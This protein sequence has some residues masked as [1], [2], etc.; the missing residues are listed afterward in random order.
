MRIALCLEYPIALRGGVSVLVEAM[1]K[2]FIRRGNEIVLV[3]DDDT[4]VLLKTDVG[5]LLTGH[6]RW[7]PQK[8]SRQSSKK[9]AQQ[10]A[11]AQVDLT[12]FHF[13]GHYGWGNRFPFNSPIY[14]LDRINIPCISTTHSLAGIFEGYCG[15][16]KPAWF[17]VCMFPLA[18]VGKMQQ[19]RCVHREIAVSQHNLKKL[20]KWYLPLKNRF[21][22]IYH[23][24][25]H[26]ELIEIPSINR[27]PVI[28]N[29]G[30][31]AKHK[32]QVLLAEAFGKIAGRFPGWTL[33][34]AG[35]DL[36]GS[37][38]EKIRRIA[39]EKLLDGR[40]QLL[41][42]RADAAEMMR[43]SAIYVQ[44][45][46]WEALGLALQEA[47]FYGCAC[48]GSRTGGIPELVED[49][50]GLLFDPGNTTQLA[51]ALE[52]MICDQEQRENFGRAAAAS[53]RKRRLFVEN[54]V[55]QHLKMYETI[56]NRS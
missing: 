9:L 12:H 50:T 20:Q 31:L 17:K 26:Q 1:L 47:M 4:E 29:V 42:E 51:R 5:K 30:H 36:D 2:E 27:M 8:F 14:F 35:K 55:Q 37:S 23:S 53:I 15:P 19:L 49:G 3:S 18:W 22:Q 45:S 44:P 48:I 11:D 13:G 6:F 21:V 52:Q 32:G 34:F 41:G 38:S 56:T 16:E 54:M 33:Q 28:L 43:C 39:K 46:F 25:L 24:R 10:L 40:I 7:F